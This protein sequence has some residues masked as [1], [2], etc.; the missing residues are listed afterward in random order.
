MAL[1]FRFCSDLLRAEA[2][3]G[4][5]AAPSFST[6]F[7]M[8]FSPLANPDHD[9]MVTGSDSLQAANCAGKWLNSTALPPSVRQN[10]LQMQSIAAEFPAKP[11]GNSVD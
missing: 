9:V 8:P 5:H 11:A 6:S 10:R 7:P 2:N 4:H 3:V 1:V